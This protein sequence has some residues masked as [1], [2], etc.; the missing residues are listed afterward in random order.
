MYVTRRPFLMTTAFA[1]SAASLYP[2]SASAEESAEA[3]LLELAPA[4]PEIVTAPAEAEAA[5]PAPAAEQP[6]ALASGPATPPAIG[7][8]ELQTLALV[9]G[10]RV[11]RGLPP[12]E[13]DQT[14]AE[15]ARAHAADMARQ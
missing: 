13:W 10:A 15:A 11:S 5:A 7:A 3:P 12:L 2:A 9:N 1:A 6:A 8:L 14:M 4:E